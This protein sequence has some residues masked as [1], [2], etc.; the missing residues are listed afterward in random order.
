LP[1]IEAIPLTPSFR[2]RVWGTTRLSPW[3]PD[4]PEKI[5]EVWFSGPGA[6]LPI[7]IKF[8]FTAE[9]LSVQVHP[10]DDYAR[11]HHDSPGKTEM[12]YVLRADPGATIGVG[13][14]EPIS[15]ERLRE[16]SLSGE[17]E[18]LMI[19]HPASAGDAFFIPAGTIHA[20]GAGLVVC[21]I[22]Q[23]SDVTYRLHDYGRPRE[24][25]LDHGIEVAAPE[26]H[27][28]KEEPR[29]LA[30]GIWRLAECEYFVTDL[31]EKSEPFDQPLDR[32]RDLFLI[33]LEGGGRIGSHACKAGT[34]WMLPR[35]EGSLRIEPDAPCRLIR[36]Y[37]PER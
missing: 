36:T 29:P 3:F 14:R 17:I 27:E 4:A 2:G 32:E 5:G 35:G 26:P 30:E 8:I 21:E 20:L 34:V 25:H 22:Q 24:L 10:D 12:W 16:A 11:E 37:A 6:P 18:D 13:L 23:H 19:W 15:K 1:G 28:G 33:F 31:L 9:K 7:L